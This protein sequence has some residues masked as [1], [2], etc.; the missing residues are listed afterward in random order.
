MR[1]G[2]STACDNRNK[3]D[4]RRKKNNLNCDYKSFQ[5]LYLLSKVSS[6]QASHWQNFIP[7][8]NYVICIKSNIITFPQAFY[9]KQTL[10][11]YSDHLRPFYGYS[12]LFE[13]YMVKSLRFQSMRKLNS[14]LQISISKMLHWP[15]ILSELRFYE[16]S[17]NFNVYSYGKGTT[18]MAYA[19]MIQQ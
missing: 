4:R 9:I 13:Q 18:T 2:E 17:I 10:L 7:F 12:Q 15:G 11:R 14:F 1:T 5:N 3:L 16:L 19:Y 6:P 8:Y